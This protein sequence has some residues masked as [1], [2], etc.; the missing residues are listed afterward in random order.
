MTEGTSSTVSGFKS[1]VKQRNMRSAE[2]EMA[3][4]NLLLLL[5]GKSCEGRY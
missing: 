4:T 3:G 2:S 5:S 1:L